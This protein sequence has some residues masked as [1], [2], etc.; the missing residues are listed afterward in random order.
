MGQF[1]ECI[2][3]MGDARS[4][5]NTCISGNVLYNE[6][7]GEGL[8]YSAIGGAGPIRDLSTQ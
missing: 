4:K 2:R 1:V 6:T 8:S 5:L 7:N 3:G